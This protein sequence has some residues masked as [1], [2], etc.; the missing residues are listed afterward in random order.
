MTLLKNARLG[1]SLVDVQLENGRISDI[2]PSGVAEAWGDT[3]QLD[4]RWLLP[5][6]WPPGG[7]DP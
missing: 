6:L 7:E 4:G 2:L 1:D 5:G 3:V